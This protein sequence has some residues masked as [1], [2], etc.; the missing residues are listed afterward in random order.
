LPLVWISCTTL[1]NSLSLPALV[2]PFLR[3]LIMHSLGT[4]NLPLFLVSCSALHPPRPPCSRRQ[5]AAVRRLL[6]LER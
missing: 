4:T 6:L 3:S 1:P 2:A 5:V